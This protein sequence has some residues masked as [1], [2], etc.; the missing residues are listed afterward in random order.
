MIFYVGL[1]LCQVPGTIGELP[2]R[3]KRSRERV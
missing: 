1:V 3:W 2:V